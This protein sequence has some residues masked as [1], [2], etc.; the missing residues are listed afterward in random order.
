MPPTPR[1]TVSDAEL[2]VLKALW[3]KGPCTVREVEARLRRKKWAY[4]TLLTLLSRLRDKGYVSQEKAPDG[5]AHIFRPAVTRSQLLGRG[6]RELS[7]R[8]AD[9]TASPLVHA[10]VKEQLTKSEIAELRQ[11]LNDMEKDG[12]Q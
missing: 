5:T 12:A 8:I 1:P 11:M 2:D 7:Q 3:E 4:N 10:L 9:G 6:L